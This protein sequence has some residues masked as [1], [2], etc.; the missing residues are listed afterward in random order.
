MIIHVVI[1]CAVLTSCTVTRSA[2]ISQNS[3]N[4]PY[5]TI[6]PLKESQR[7]SLLALYGNN[8]IFVEEYLD[9][10]L[11]A[12]SYYPELR[13]SPIEFKFSAEATTMAARPRPSSMLT[14]RRYIIVIN[15]KEEF[16]GIRLSDVPYN[17]QI[18][19][20]GHELAHIADYQKHNLF[21][22]MGILFRYSSK[23]RK[24]LFEKEID[25]A[26]IERGL[27]WQL[28]DW[29]QFALS[30]DNDTSEEYRQFKRE[31]YLSPAEIEQQIEFY[32][33]YG[34]AAH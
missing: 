6:A 14:N 12:L 30:E 29:A 24:P 2:M 17:A 34:N 28:Y 27:G 3:S 20:I 9:P 10:T 13:D 21:G 11:I 5:R 23:A 31:H 1:C 19:I 25:R 15:N 26:T 18:G 33:R 8:K 32:A 7:D 16:E 22:V 4:V